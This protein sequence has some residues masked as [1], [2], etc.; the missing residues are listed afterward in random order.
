MAWSTPLTAVS[1]TTLTAAQWN[2]SVRDNLNE[3]AVAKATTPGSIFVGTGVNTIAERLILEA[4]VDTAQTTTSTS[5]ANLTT[6]GPTVASMTTGVK[7]MVW[8]NAE[9]SNSASGTVLAS[10]EVSGATTIAAADNRAVFNDAG[11]NTHRGGVS[12]LMALTA[13]SNNFRMQYRTTSATAT[14]KNRRM[15]VMAL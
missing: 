12:A 7:A 5:Y 3:T 1:N 13:G 2:A 4:V 8:T 10:F 14:F 9:L 6:D 11:T 15:Q